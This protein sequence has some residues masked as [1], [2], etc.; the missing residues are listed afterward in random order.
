MMRVNLIA[1]ERRAAKA[2]GRAMDIAQRATLGGTALLVV[3]ALAVG[4]RYWFMWQAESRV[5][6]EIAAAKREEARLA[7]VLKQVADFDA[8]REELQRRVSLIDDL[9]R[10][11]NAHV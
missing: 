4:G 3:T 2:A 8:Q 5:A 6:N 1:G 10:G 11:Q 7:E 9:R